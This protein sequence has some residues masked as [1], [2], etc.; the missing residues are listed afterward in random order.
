M[1]LAPKEVTAATALWMKGESLRELHE[2]VKEG[3]PA[4]AEAYVLGQSEVMPYL[5]RLREELDAALADKGRPRKLVSA[6][7]LKEIH[8]HFERIRREHP[9]WKPRMISVEIAGALDTDHRTVMVRLRELRLVR[10]ANSI[11][12]SMSVKPVSPLAAW[13]LAGN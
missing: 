13:I 6:S 8:S 4:A 3:G 12:F 1:R 2:L 9:D 10:P 11:N 5:V 7:E